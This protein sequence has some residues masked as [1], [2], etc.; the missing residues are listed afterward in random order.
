MAQ[1]RKEDLRHEGYH[2]VVRITPE[3]GPVKTDEA[4]EVVLHPHLIEQG[5]TAFVAAA[6]SGHL[7]L[8]PSKDGEVRGPLRGLK[9]RLQEF[10]RETITDKNVAP[11]HGWRHRFKTV[12][13]EAGVDQGVLDAIQGHAPTSVGGR[14]GDV[15]L[16]TI[17]EAIGKLPRINIAEGE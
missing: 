17:A 4:R 5:F 9:N 14:Y 3:A 16:R 7:F 2:W 11:N 15:T 6:P 12:G 10:A 8:R 13:R 1:L